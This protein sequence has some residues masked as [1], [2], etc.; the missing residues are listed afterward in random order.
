VPPA[1]L[2]AE[3]THPFAAHLREFLRD[4]RHRIR[5]LA[6]VE[7]ASIEKTIRFCDG[8]IPKATAFLKVSVSMLYRKW[9]AYGASSG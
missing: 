5:P 9:E 2:L 4:E 3:D 1:R 6:K 7:C 8:S